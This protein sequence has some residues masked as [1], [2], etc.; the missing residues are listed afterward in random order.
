MLGSRLLAGI[1]AIALLA[2]HSHGLHAQPQRTS[3]L[4]QQ[5]LDTVVSI[6]R[7]SAEGRETPVGTGFIVASSRNHLMLIS[8]RHV[9]TDAEGRLLGDLAYRLNRPGGASLL[10]RDTD[11]MHAGGGHWFVSQQDD[12]AARFL[13]VLAGASIKAIPLE[14][15]VDEA[16]VKAGTPLAALG[17]P[18]GLR[19]VDHAKPIARSGMIGRAD[20]ASLLADLFVFPGN[21]G[22]PVLYVPPLRVGGEAASDVVPHEMLVGMVSSFISYNDIALSNQTR[23]PRVVFEENAGLANL[24]PAWVVR[25]FVTSGEVNAMDQRLA[26]A[27]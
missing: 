27:R 1:L 23:R 15:F 22:G 26:G 25:R 7:L 11:L 16:Q 8:A 6:E 18:L 24:V 5:W 14:R 17:F 20:P 3:Q 19:S 9:V 21:S 4:D 10:I 2:L 13:P 12:I